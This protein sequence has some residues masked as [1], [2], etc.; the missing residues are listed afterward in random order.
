MFPLL[1]ATLLTQTPQVKPDIEYRKA[2]DQSMKLD[3]YSPVTLSEKPAPL[4]VVI[5][6]GSWMT[7]K[8][9]DMAV[10]AQTLAKEGFAA[11]TISY[12]LA[13]KDKWPSQIDDC[14]AA[15][16]YL[17]ANSGE[18]KID[19]NRISSLGASAGGHLALLLGL[20][21]TRDKT[22]KDY[23]LVSSR[24][25]CVINVFG[26]TDMLNDY[27]PTLA[28]LLCMQVLGKSFDKSTEELKQFSPLTY[29]GKDAPPIFTLHG[30]ADTLV[31]VK[32]A[33]RLDEALK[34]FNITHETVLVDGMGH[35]L[36]I[37][38]PAVADAVKKAIAFLKA[39]MMPA[40]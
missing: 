6:G 32:Q 7:G 1:V 28:G 3:F 12:R 9:Q 21:D 35:E 5:H 16:R 20:T 8:R 37:E 30:R 18:Y 4:V 10:F 31:P 11:A 13:P 26:P 23:P 14:Q 38:K 2:N 29:V 17:R 40:E 34:K 39:R 24:T 22:T 25:Q 33:E 15:V 27:D 36:P 19:P